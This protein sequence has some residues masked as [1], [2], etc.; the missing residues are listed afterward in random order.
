MVK[1]IRRTILKVLDFFVLLVTTPAE[2]GWRK[3]HKRNNLTSM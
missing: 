3:S 2:S 1:A